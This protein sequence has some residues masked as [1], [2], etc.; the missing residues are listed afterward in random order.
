MEGS[1][2]SG[3]ENENLWRS[4][5]KNRNSVLRASCSPRHDLFPGEM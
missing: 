3:A 2:P 1:G 4:E 5:V